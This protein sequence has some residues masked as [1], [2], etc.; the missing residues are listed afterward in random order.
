MAYELIPYFQRRSL[1]AKLASALEE[2]RSNALA[3]GSVGQGVLD[4]GLAPVAAS[5]IAY[6]WQQSCVTSEV[7]EWRR[8]MKVSPKLGSQS[9]LINVRDGGCIVQCFALKCGERCST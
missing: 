3:Q 8:A 1:H 2:V 7:A 6:H 5:T 4:E 9:G